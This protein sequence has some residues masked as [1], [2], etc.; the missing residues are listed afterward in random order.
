MHRRNEIDR[1]KGFEQPSLVQEKKER[2]E[3]KVTEEKMPS[4]S[5]REFLD[6]LKSCDNEYKECVPQV[7]RYDRMSQDYLHG[8]EFAHNYEERCKLATKIHKQR[9]DRRAMKDRVEL[10]DKIAKFCAD[11]QN[12]QFIDRLKSLLKEQEKAEEYVL[13]ERHYNM[14][15]GL[16][17]DI[18]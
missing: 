11:K 5:I 6:F 15:G 13:S 18:N 10:V 8:I 4:E 3:G 1:T 14:R 12:K 17:D 9:N 2:G 7:H 16:S